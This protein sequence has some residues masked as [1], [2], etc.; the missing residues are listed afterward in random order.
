MPVERNKV[1]SSQLKYSGRIVNLRIDTVVLKDGTEAIREVIE[2]RPC[3]VVVPY[4]EK[5][6]EI[7]M[8]EQYR[9]A[10][11]QPMLEVPAGMHQPDETLE[12]CARR[13]LLEET[14]YEAGKL[15]SLGAYYTSPGFT[16]EQHYLY[17]ATQLVMRSNGPKDMLEIGRRRAVKRK[18]LVQLLQSGELTDGKTILAL[19][20]TARYIKRS[21]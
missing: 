6:D 13:E 16:D 14:G 18:E 3:A 12:D 2:H 21:L 20:W 9:D 17:L 15:Q 19:L 7:V 8:I 5:S 11:R 10:V 4:L 1:I